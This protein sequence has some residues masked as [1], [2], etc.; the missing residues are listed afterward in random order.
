MTKF[1][2]E[3]ARFSLLRLFGV[4]IVFIAAAPVFWYHVQIH[5]D[6]VGAGYENADLYQDIY[7]SFH[8]GF[9]RLRAGQLP[10]WNAKQLC[11]TPFLAQPSSAIFQPLNAVFLFL[12]T[13]RAMAVHA[14]LCLAMMGIGFVI[15]A[16]ALDLGY[17]AA[18]I[19]ATL[20]AFCGA[21]AA[22]ASRPALAASLAW[23]PFLFW[24][25]RETMR[26][27]H[28]GSSAAAGL[29][30]AALI[31]SGAPALVT[32]ML[33]T[34][35]AY[36]VFLGFCAPMEPRGPGVR[37]RFERL[38]IVAAI[39]IAVSAIQWL[40]TAAWMFDLDHAWEALWTTSLPAQV[41]VS[42]QDLLVQ[43]LAPKP[44][45]LP[46]VAYLGAAAMA[47]TPVAFMHHASR[48]DAFFFAL[49]SAGALAVVLLAS[50]M[51]LPFP[52]VYAAFPALFMLATLSAL[53][54]DRLLLTR[55]GTH[56]LRR[57]YAAIVL[58]VAA[59]I[60]FYIS[61]SEAR[62][63]LAVLLAIMGPVVL[64]RWP[65][66]S[67]L[68]GLVLAA[69]LFTDLTTANANLYAHPFIDVPECYQ[70][71]GHTLQ[72]TEEQVMG[73][74]IMSSAPLLDFGLPSRLGMIRAGLYDAG[75]LSPL[76]RDQATWWRRLGPDDPPPPPTERQEAILAPGAALP[77]L[78]NPMAVRAILAAP[79][80][81]LASGTVNWP[82]VR[83]TSVRT[84]D[85]ARLLMNATAWPRAIWVPSWQ[86]VDGV[87]GAINTL[88]SAD[89]DGKR[90]C[91]IDRDSLGY[92]KLAALVPG[93]RDPAK[94]PLPESIEDA[95]CTLEDHGA[96]H[97]ILRTE[98]PQPGIAVLADCYAPGW[99]ASLDGKSS[100]ILRAN[101]LFRGIAVP[102]GEHRI[103][104][105]Y[106][107]R[108]FAV[109]AAVTL[110]ALGLLALL[111]VI[112]YVRG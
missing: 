30:G 25:I 38:L 94:T 4:A 37:E 21:S 53:G 102:A 76:T 82:G 70:R 91:T 5:P 22:A 109:G 57:R 64:L 93:P 103:V 27:A 100:P 99:Q 84:E 104:F 24:G 67:V 29:A 33:L 89:F 73:G 15:F 108:P 47:A 50:K 8:Y 69:A 56:A 35:L 26:Q 96:E 107:P 98:A 68:A 111:G 60:L 44:G 23:T 34:A 112:D 45:A 78:L 71:Y 92:D 90:E 19:G 2:F 105:T 87:P 106:R 1:A 88:G 3:G 86:V 32:L 39:T 66:F 42:L 95:T 97:V 79:D 10:L 13:E 48:R 7:P 54:F 61:S 40:P 83:L 59:A 62:G 43:L 12:A 6:A 36:G 28:F 49:A 77:Q 11:G 20:Y 65:R 46:H 101:G 41:P 18:L 81:P 16:R 85:G 51:P 80:D 14:F 110:G 75:G 72:T 17:T 9:S 63:R 74:R 31:L 55:R 58:A 52:Y